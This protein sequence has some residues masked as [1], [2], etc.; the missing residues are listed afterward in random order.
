MNDIIED[1]FVI[2]GQ[3]FRLVNM[4][5]KKGRK[6]AAKDAVKILIQRPEDRRPP[7]KDQN[8]EVLLIKKGSLVIN[9]KS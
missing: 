5:D 8:Y 9:P 7:A 3:V 6:C 2:D 4:W 1:L